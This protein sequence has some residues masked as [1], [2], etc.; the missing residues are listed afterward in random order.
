M[1]IHGV[2]I[3]ALDLSH[4]SDSFLASVILFRSAGQV[5]LRSNDERYWRFLSPKAYLKK[6]RSI[7]HWVSDG[8]KGW[9]VFCALAFASVAPYPFA[10]AYSDAAKWIQYYGLAI[11]LFGFCLA[12]YAVNSNLKQWGLRSIRGRI[13]HYLRDFPVLPIL[14]TSFV[15]STGKSHSRSS[16]KGISLETF[17]GERSVEDRLRK[18]EKHYEELVGRIIDVE[19]TQNDDKRK[20][21]SELKS[22]QHKSEAQVDDLRFS[23]SKSVENGVTTEILGIG[24]FVVGAVYATV[25]DI[26]LSIMSV[27]S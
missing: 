8:Y 6:L 3:Q 5:S 13:W 12:L 19:K 10:F 7:G 25:P 27:L 18:L 15:M 9:G 14:R 21:F 16:A 24:L 23:I 11:Q 2:Q 4:S 17:S 1:R 20:L 22:V 26:P